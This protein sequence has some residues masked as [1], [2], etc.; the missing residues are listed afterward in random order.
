MLVG[1][2][3]L[4]QNVVQRGCSHFTKRDESICPEHRRPVPMP[5]PWLPAMPH[6]APDSPDPIL[7]LFTAPGVC[8]SVAGLGTKLIGTGGA[9]GRAGLVKWVLCWG[10]GHAW[11]LCSLSGGQGTTV[12]AFTLEA[13]LSRPS[14]LQGPLYLGLRR[15]ID[16]YPEAK[17][18]PGRCALKQSRL[19]EPETRSRARC[20]GIVVSVRPW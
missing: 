15:K 20:Q 11:Y 19:E 4:P 2:H 6:P 1:C 13:L 8:P 10:G 3:E 14:S 18:R 7:G 5:P 9:G 17:Y 12:F 16:I